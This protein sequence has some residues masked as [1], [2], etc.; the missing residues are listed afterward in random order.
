MRLSASPSAGQFADRWLAS[1]RISAAEFLRALRMFNTVDHRESKIWDNLSV[2]Q[3]ELSM[4][5]TSVGFGW[6]GCSRAPQLFLIPRCSREESRR[7]HEEQERRQSCYTL[8]H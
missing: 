3:K 6:V 4:F 7:E 2:L 8:A 5:R 1:S